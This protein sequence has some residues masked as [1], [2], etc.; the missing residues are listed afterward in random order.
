MFLYLPSLWTKN[1]IFPKFTLNDWIDQTCQ[2]SFRDR[3][4]WQPE[5]LAT[6]GNSFV[7]KTLP[8][9]SSNVPMVEF[10]VTTDRSICLD[11]QSNEIKV[12]TNVG[13][14]AIGY[15]NLETEIFVAAT[16]AK[17]GDKFAFMNNTLYSFLSNCNVSINN[18]TAGTSNNLD[19]QRAS[20]KQ[21]YPAHKAAQYR[22]WLVKATLF[23]QTSMISTMSDK[24][25][26]KTRPQR[27]Y[28]KKCDSTHFGLWSTPDSGMLSSNQADKQQRRLWFARRC[29]WCSV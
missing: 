18:E 22:K 23:R 17:A 29:I 26:L 1:W 7:Q 15:T 6:F 11:L 10:V 9:F 5:V 16:K 27:R 20:L 13:K 4:L 25:S 3:F 24:H 21:N 28:L 12:A 2:P 8:V 14:G 19:A